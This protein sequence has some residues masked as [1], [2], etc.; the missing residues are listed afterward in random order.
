MGKIP[1]VILA[2]KQD[3]PGSLPLSDVALNFEK[4]HATS[5]A[6]TKIYP[7]SAIT[8]AGV[9]DALSATVETAQRRRR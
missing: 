1:V 2:N 8:G 9:H 5:K 4:S 6:P 7:I 3:L